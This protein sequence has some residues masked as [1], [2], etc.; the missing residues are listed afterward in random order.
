MENIDILLLGNSIKI[1]TWISK[2]PF[3]AL[4]K[5]SCIAREATFPAQSLWTWHGMTWDLHCLYITLWT[6]TEDSGDLVDMTKGKFKE[7][8]GPVNCQ[9][10]SNTCLSTAIDCHLPSGP[11]FSLVSNEG[12]CVWIWHFLLSGPVWVLARLNPVEHTILYVWVWTGEKL[13]YVCKT[14]M[15]ARLCYVCKKLCYVCKKIAGT[16]FRIVLG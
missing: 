11:L 9:M 16:E 15:Y 12:S 8:K 6:D 4:F 2:G 5:I 13:C 3:P 7:Q 1:F 10:L 14:V